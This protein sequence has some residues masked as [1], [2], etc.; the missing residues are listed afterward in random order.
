MQLSIP[1]RLHAAMVVYP[2]CA[3][4][5]VESA[6]CR[7]TRP[8]SREIGFATESPTRTTVENFAFPRASSTVSALCK[9]YPIP[10]HPPR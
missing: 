2:A 10:I 1:I 4:L 8:S 9:S 7:S 3:A 6:P 5:C